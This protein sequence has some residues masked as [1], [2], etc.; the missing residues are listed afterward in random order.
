M[1][2]EFSVHDGVYEMFMKKIIPSSVRGLFA[3]PY[4]VGECIFL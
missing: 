2:L 4:F 1:K 3:T